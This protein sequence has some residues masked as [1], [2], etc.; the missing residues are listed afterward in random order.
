MARMNN[1]GGYRQLDLGANG[2]ANDGLPWREWARYPSIMILIGYHGTR[3]R[4]ERFDLERAG[5]SGLAARGRGVHFHSDIRL[6]EPFAGDDGRVILAEITLHNPAILPE[7]ETAGQESTPAEARQ[8]SDALI[9]AGHDGLIVE[10][11]F[12]GPE[13]VVFDLACIRVIDPNMALSDRQAA[14]P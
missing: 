13:I 1:Y 4:F 9:E 10:H 11:E 6:A 12:S 8:F 14:R 3:E 2:G 5:A 7:T